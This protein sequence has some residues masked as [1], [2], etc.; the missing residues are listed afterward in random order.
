MPLTLS[1]T[2]QAIAPS[3]TLKMNALVGEMRDRGEDVISLSVGEPD[4]ITPEHIREAGKRAIDEGK[5]RYTAASGMPSLRSAIA[6][7]LLEEKGLRYTREEIIV[8]NGAKQVIL[9]ARQA[10]VNPADEVLLP[11]PCWVSYPEMIQM[12]GGTPVWINTTKEQGFI[13]T[14]EQIE[15]AITPR[16]KARMRNSPSN[17]TGAGWRR[18]PLTLLARLAVKHQFY[19]ISDEIYEKLVYDGAEHISVATLNKQVFNQTIVVSGFS[20]AYAMTGWR[21]GY[22]A[23]PRPV[24]S[25]MAAYQSHA[26][27]NANSIAQY[28]GLAAL[29]GDQTCV[30]EMAAAFSRRRMLMLNCLRLVPHVS[31]FIPKGAFYVLLD[32][33]ET[34]GLSLDQKVIYSA[35]DFAELLLKNARVSVVAGD[36]FGAPGYVRLSY[37]VSDERILEAVRRIGNFTDKLQK[38]R[39]QKLA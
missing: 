24:I 22:A 18:E 25:A 17:P 6:K 35:G 39:I 21:L 13:P 10:I 5:T 31:T 20:K 28:A 34:F 15:K 27:G 11:A 26:T 29:K 23:G 1:R 37:A 2:C 30:N 3:A 9:G 12:A 14:A 19:I 33:R 7:Y 32:V 38:T 36:A 4:F 8:G 16:T